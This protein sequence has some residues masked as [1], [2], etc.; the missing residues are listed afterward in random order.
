MTWLN[1]KS[2]RVLISLG[3]LRV[4]DDDDDDDDGVM[5]SAPASNK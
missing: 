5:I 2:C 1:I 4:D 3:L